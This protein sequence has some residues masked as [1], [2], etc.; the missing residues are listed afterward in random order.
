MVL[1]LERAGVVRRQP[2]VARSIEVLVAPELLP[3]LRSSHLKRIKTAGAKA[4]ES[5]NVASPVLA[6]TDTLDSLTY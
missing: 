2:G 3:V 6:K 1:T 4:A 5:A